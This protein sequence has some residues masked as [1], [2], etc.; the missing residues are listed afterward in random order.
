MSDGQRELVF[1]PQRQAVHLK[2]T[3]TLWEMLQNAR[4]TGQTITMSMGKF[5]VGL[6]CPLRFMLDKTSFRLG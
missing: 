6:F 3:G 1:E 5:N 4:H 2:L